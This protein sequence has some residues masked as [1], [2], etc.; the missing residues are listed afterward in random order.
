MTRFA[1]RA[2][3]PVALMLALCGAGAQAATLKIACSGLGKE[4]EL[5]KGAADAWGK[6]TGNT[7][8]V[9]STPND[10]SERLALYQQV[11]ASGSDKIDVFQVEMNQV[12]L[13][14]NQLLDLTGYSKG[15]EKGHFPSMVNN[16][17]VGGRL[18]AM[19]W[20]IDAG[21]L[22]YRKDLLEKYKQDVPQTWDQLKA[23]AQ[24]IQDAERK[25]GKD[26]MWG[27][28]WQGRA[29]EG[30]TCNALEWVASH[31]GGTIVDDSGKVTIGNPNAVKAI[32]M[33]AGFVGTISP[34]AVLNYAEEES[35]GPFQNGNAVFMRNW[36]YAWAA[37]QAADSPVKDKVGVAVLPRGSGDGARHAATLGGQELAVSKHS[38][39]AALAVELVLY[40]AGPEVQK[41]RALKGSYNP[42][43][44]ELY[45]DADIKKA[46]PFMGSLVRT[47]SSAVARPTA[48]TGVR[49]N[50]VS[51][52]FQNTVHEVLSK[53]A[54]PE[55]AIARLNTRL[56]QISRGGK[57]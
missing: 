7:V 48:A 32:T 57:W 20:F 3:A 10:A 2:L 15:V 52:E 6:K 1:Q 53:T 28:V 55:E 9:V 45:K 18:V 5:C 36:P 22:Y 50:Q 42:T 34:T 24:L 30:L 31:G 14:A 13:L 4:L 12:G 51:S 33:A 41:E 8:E 25:A 11:L 54:K 44:V 23:T 37:A 27:Y 39:N 46:N 38:K 29:Y 21:L 47:F 49:Y 43:I 35:R 16:S 40:M 56:H 26:K 17:A 19:P